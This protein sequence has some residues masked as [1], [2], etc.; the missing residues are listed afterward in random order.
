MSRRSEEPR[1]FKLR[2]KPKQE[3]KDTRTLKELWTDSRWE[4]TVPEQTDVYIERDAPR[5]QTRSGRT[6][7]ANQY[8]DMLYYKA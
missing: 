6:V 4:R 7:R 2:D 1:A 5:I 3:S 8:D